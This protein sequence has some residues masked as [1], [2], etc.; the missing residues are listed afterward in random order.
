MK[1]KILGAMAG[2][3]VASVGALA[4]VAV[5][6]SAANLTPTKAETVQTTRRIWVV[7]NDNW[8]VP[9]LE[10]SDSA[11]V[12]AFVDENDHDEFPINWIMTDYS[13]GLGYV[14]IAIRFTTIIFKPAADWKNQSVNLTLSDPITKLANAGDVYYLNS[15]TNESP[16]YNRNVSKGTAGMSSSQLA[17]FLSF[18]NTCSASYANGYNAYPQLMVD[19]YL[20]S[21]EKARS[22]TVTKDNEEPRD[23]IT[24]AQ[25]IGKMRELY[26]KDHGTNLD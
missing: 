9:T 8:W 3:S 21:D 19:F 14:D 18:F 15:G 11:H 26:N 22:G 17:W 7:N 16:N 1:V 2:L 4:G 20:A 6:N 5:A 23:D 25:K 13:H 24:F 10:Q 12:Y